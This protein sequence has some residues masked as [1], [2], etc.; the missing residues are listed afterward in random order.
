MARIIDDTFIRTELGAPQAVA[1]MREALVAHS[2]GD[3]VGP[4]R[5]TA[6]LDDGLLVFTA[7]R[8]RGEWYGFR[9]Y[10][11]LPLP[12][13]RAAE[14]LTVVHDEATGE[15]RGIAI[16][17]ELEPRRTGAL[18]GVAAGALARRDASTLALIGTGTQAYAQ[19]WAINAGHTLTEVR[20]YSPTPGKPQAFAGRAAAELGLDVRPCATARD[21]V[22]GADLIVLATTARE[23]VIET[24]WIEPGAY[25]A[26]VGP[27]ARGASELPA[28]LG[29]ACD[30][31]VSDS[32]HQW[33][34]MAPTALGEDGAS[35]VGLGDVVAGL[36]PGRT[37]AA[38]RTLYLSTGLAGTEAYLLARLVGR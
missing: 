21:A 15:V 35:V 4:A 10:A 6:N 38:Q 3:L 31:I 32:P 28:D 22:A 37:T 9:S 1:W 34:D 23:P 12:G 27:K 5:V 26:S 24:A 25:V 33:A 18:G 2:A 17:H 20:V 36:V 30:V 29:A 16:G 7:G 11:T 19:L 14:Q 8:L 13:G